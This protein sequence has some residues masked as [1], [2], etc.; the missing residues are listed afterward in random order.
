MSHEMGHYVLNHGVKLALYSGILFL[1]AFA[2]TNFVFNALVRKRGAVWGVRGIADPAGLPLLALIF[3]AF[4][5]SGHA[6]LQIRS[7]A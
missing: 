7:P 5:F 4:G 3:G 1:V 2:I 6:R